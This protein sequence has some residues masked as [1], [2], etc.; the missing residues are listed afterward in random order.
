MATITHKENPTRKKSTR[1]PS[2]RNR[3]KRILPKPPQKKYTLSY[4]GINQRS[5][6]PRLPELKDVTEGDR[7]VF[8]KATEIDI[9]DLPN[10][11]VARAATMQDIFKNFDKLA[12][13]ISTI[14]RCGDRCRMVL[15]I[16]K[17]K[18]MEA[19]V[20][21]TQFFEKMPHAV[22][23]VELALGRDQLMPVIIEALAKVSSARRKDPLAESTEVL[24]AVKDLF[25]PK[26]RLSAKCIASVFGITLSQLAKA[27]GKSKQALSKTPDAKNLHPLLRPYERVARLRV[28]KDDHA[29]KVWLA[30]SNPHLDGASPIELLLNG[31]GQCVADLVEDMMLGNPS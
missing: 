4:M 29:F 25:S 10:V 27:L 28:F 14:D 1:S 5:A 22:G 23:N 19:L 26:G 6:V 7:L 20:E 21:L 9:S 13:I 12:K 24:E 18:P 8:E 11:V 31:E 15:Y 2:G 30:A 16:E 17:Q 3:V